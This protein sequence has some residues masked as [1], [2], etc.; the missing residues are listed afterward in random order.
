[1][2]APMSSRDI[3]LAMVTLK[4]VADHIAPA[5]TGLRNQGKATLMPKETV[6][7]VHPVTGEPLGHITHTNPKPKAVVDDEAAL[8]PWMADNKPEALRDETTIE[9]TDEQ[10]LDVLRE[11]A[12]HLLGSRVT[13]A[14]W[15]VNEVLKKSEKDGK[16]AAPG[17]KVE[18]PK[19]TVSVYPDVSKSDS[20]LDAIRAGLV[21]L[22]GTVAA[23]T[24]GK[25]AA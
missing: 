21:A 7:A 6:V 20:I 4:F 11:H 22:D 1:M 8:L 5:Q 12:P 14:D 19:G 17:I 13:V 25:E 3:A 16:P 18:Q 2:S 15:A 9:A 10:L 24:T 23:I